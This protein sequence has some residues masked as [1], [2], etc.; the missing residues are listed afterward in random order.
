MS[1]YILGISCFY[2]DSAAAL[3][4]DGEI[5]CAVQEER[6]SRVK[7]DS[8]FPENAINYCLKSQ[9]INLDD[10]EYV[11]YYEKPLLTFERL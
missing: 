6:F 11:A 10:I 3:I 5:I 1:K 8:R 2:H 4:R 7:H 9:N